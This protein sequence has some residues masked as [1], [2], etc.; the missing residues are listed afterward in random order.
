ML[1]YTH[2]YG[3]TLIAAQA[4][5]LVLADREKLKLFAA[6]TLGVGLA[7]LPWVW[8]AVE[9]A[10]RKG[11]LRANLGWIQRP[12]LIDL[13]GF[14]ASAAGLISP[15][16]AAAL[17]L[18]VSLVLLA[19]GLPVAI[20]KASPVV[21]KRLLFAA[22][23]ASIPPVTGFAISQL[24]RESVWGTRHLV[25]SV[26]PFAVLLGAAIQAIHLRWVT[27]MAAC[28]FTV[29]CAWGGYRAA[30][31]PNPRMNYEVLLG[32]MI[33]LNNHKVSK[34]ADTIYFFDRYLGLP[35]TYHLRKN[36]SGNSWTAKTFLEQPPAKVLGDRF[37]VV[38]NSKRWLHKVTPQDVLRE[39]G[40]KIGPGAWAG[41]KWDRVF[42]FYASK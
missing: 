21:R 15:P 9:A 18:V 36:D 20:R 41:D 3:W 24:S 37:W 23:A 33:D 7:F 1:V 27:A 2:Y 39:R 14:Y 35:M 30:F 32:Q 8:V 22:L 5:Y 17:L 13:L 16:P 11:G 12:G 26:L 38:Y 40:Y 28:I 29:S 4:L 25:I 31:L 19:L 6:A 10:I 34:P 42:V